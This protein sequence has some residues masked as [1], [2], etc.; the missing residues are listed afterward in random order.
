MSSGS[1][2]R[3]RWGR[4]PAPP[5]IVF[6]LARAQER[7]G[8]A[9]FPGTPEATEL[10]GSRRSSR[11]SQRI[12]RRFKHEKLSKRSSAMRC[13]SSA[14]S[15]FKTEPS[16]SRVSAFSSLLSASGSLFGQR[17]EATDAQGGTVAPDT[18]PGRR[19]VE[20]GELTAYSRVVGARFRRYPFLPG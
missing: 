20:G 1:G 7:F 2:G 18:E 11:A 6:V 12:S 5:E 15:N 17:L 8:A 9:D 14:R 10:L 19:Y 4:S 13:E 16:G 3:G